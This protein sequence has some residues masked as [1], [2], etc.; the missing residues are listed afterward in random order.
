MAEPVTIEN[1]P[2]WARVLTVFWLGEI[3]F[4]AFVTATGV[5]WLGGEENGAAVVMILG[6]LLVIGAG[7]VMSEVSWR[8][9]RLKGA[10][11]EMTDQ[12]FRDR[13]LSETPIRGATSTGGSCSTASPGA[14]SSIWHPS[15]ARPIASPGATG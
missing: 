6:G 13:R 9:A 15:S 2:F 14:C 3:L 1:H 8:V 5:S 7:L 10:A 11:I 4:G 12:G